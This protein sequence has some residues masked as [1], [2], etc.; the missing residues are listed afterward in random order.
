MKILNKNKSFLILIF[1]ILIGFFYRIYGLNFNYSFWN[2][3]ENVAV[4]A[5]AI[6][7]RGY[8]VLDNGYSTG[9][10]K[11]LQYWLSAGSVKIFG[12]D[13]FA[14]RFPSVIFGILTIF[15][16]Y[17]LGKDL[18]NKK[19][20]LISAFLLTFLKIEILWSRQAR[21]Y[22]GLQFFYLLG[23]FFLYKLVQSKK[24]NWKYFL[25][26]LISGILASLMHGLGIFLFL[27]GFIYIIYNRLEFVRKKWRWFLV[28]FL[29]FISFTF[30]LRD[31][32]LWPL[33]RFNEFNNFYYYRVFLTHN[34]LSIS[35]LTFL[36][37]FWLGFKKVYKKFSLF[38]IFLGLQ[39]LIISF[40]LPQPFIRY[41]Y[42]VFPFLILLS[43]FFIYKLS[44]FFRNKP[45]SNLFLILFI[46]LFI[47]SLK[48]KLVFSPQPTY[49]LNED[50]QEIPEVDYKKIYSFIAKKLNENQDAVFI[51]NWFDHPIWYLGED[52]LNYW[53]R[54][55]DYPDQ[56]K[57]DFSGAI[58]IDNIVYLKEIISNEKKGIIILES[59]ETKLPD[60]TAE[61]IRS[62]LKKEFEWD[63]LYPTQPRY[64]P[65]EIYS[66]GID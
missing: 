38:L 32:I 53:L 31:R 57:D 39:I 12:L 54:V 61:Y 44:T 46:L 5:R 3:E 59:W 60:G 56:I 35:F 48:N 23:A 18:F 4:F 49:S 62:N 29:I 8:P 52:K 21:P 47:F 42:I 9:L 33:E 11:W 1:L 16:I 41:F 20:G 15:I 66:W 50:M 40:F 10:Y 55:K 37:I 34:Y 2:D 7:Q 19:V 30:F 43:S 17:L 13:E 6:L 22:Q 28:T 26:F 14:I 65:V 27:F 25:G 51:S 63:R 45:I 24:I 36:A 64:W 58:I